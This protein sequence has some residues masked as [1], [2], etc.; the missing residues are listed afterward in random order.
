MHGAPE[1]TVMLPSISALSAGLSLLSVEGVASRA[2]IASITEL[3]A[4]VALSV[5]LTEVPHAGT[6]AASSSAARQRSERD[7]MTTSVPEF[8]VPQRG[9]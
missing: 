1:S 8:F 9:A 4:S 3:G 7:V 5:A 2:A 6:S